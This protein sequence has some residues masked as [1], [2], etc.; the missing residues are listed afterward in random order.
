MARNAIAVGV[1]EISKKAGGRE[2]KKRE[3]KKPPCLFETG[4]LLVLLMRGF[5]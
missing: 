4:R 2:K 5:A 1:C 3:M